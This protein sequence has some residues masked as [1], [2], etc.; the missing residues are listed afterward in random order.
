MLSCSD[1]FSFSGVGEPFGIG[2]DEPGLLVVGRSGA[3]FGSGGS[4]GCAAAQV[5]NAL[6]I[7][8]FLHSI[9]ACERSLFR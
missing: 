3:A 7:S 4:A 5:S 1:G 6:R 2:F 9:V 8:S